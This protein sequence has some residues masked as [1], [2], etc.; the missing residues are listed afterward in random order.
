MAPGECCIH[1]VLLT[2]R[3]E[4]LRHVIQSFIE[5]FIEITA[6][7][8]NVR[9]R[10]MELASFIEVSTAAIEELDATLTHLVDEQREIN[11]YLQETHNETV[12][13]RS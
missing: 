9:A 1:R 12:S 10:T 5:S 13:L 8:G 11:A 2:S 4:S 6:N 7:S 3:N